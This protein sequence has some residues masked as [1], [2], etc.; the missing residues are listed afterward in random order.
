MKHGRITASS[1]R[2]HPL[3]GS[4]HLQTALPTLLRPLP[5]LAL[6]VERWE[7]PDG[8]FVDLGWFEKPR[9]GAPLAV[10]VHGLTGGFES[11]YLRATA[12]RLRHAGWAGLILQLRGAGDQPNRMAR[13]YHQ[14][15]TADLIA[16][17]QRLRAGHPGALI[18]NL[19]WSLGGNIVLKAA[20]E[21]GE[22]HPAD[23]LTA[24]S[25]PFA[26]EPCAQRLRQGA[27][28][29]YQRRLLRDLKA[30]ALRKH[31]AVQLPEMI[32]VAAM[33]RAR[34]FFEFDD[35][36][37]AP[38]HGFEDALDY[39]RRCECGPFLRAIRRPTLIVHSR[40]DPFMSPD[41]LPQ[42]S[43][44]AP[45][46]TLELSERGGHVGFVAR[47]AWG[48]PLFWLERR[49]SDWLQQQRGRVDAL[50]Q[51]SGAARISVQAGEA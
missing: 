9:P 21:L 34:D 44:L 38:L 29:I 24:V 14:G 43:D 20:G 12:A 50:A 15:D 31:A 28:R 4:A 18:A 30:M 10:L 6:E 51:S 32:D 23:L 2:P 42:A 5:P 46:V 19:G 33:L 35:A 40:D 1:F 22:K 47:N 11:K 16:L 3:L 8:D 39:Y 27:S 7:R 36:W 48:G 26:L 13:N 37:T 25:V 41:I 45:E 17:L 49:L